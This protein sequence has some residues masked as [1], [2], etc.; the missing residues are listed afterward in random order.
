MRD[1]M[2]FSIP[3][4]VCLSVM[5]GAIPARGG[6]YTFSTIDFPGAGCTVATGINASGQIV[7]YYSLEPSC[8]GSIQSFV[9]TSGTFTTINVPGANSTYAQGINASGDVSG[10]CFGGS[11]DS[12]LLDTEGNYTLFEFP[13]ACGTEAYG[14]NNSEQIVGSYTFTC[15]GS[16][17][18]F[19]YA[20]GSFS[21]LDFP[22]AS[23]GGSTEAFGINSSGNIVGRYGTS[24]PYVENN[25][26]L[27]AS[28][29]FTT[30][31]VPGAVLTSAI[32]INDTGTITGWYED[33]ASILHGFVLAGGTFTTI[34]FPGA[35]FTQAESINASGEVAGVYED[36]AGI[37][38]FLATPTFTYAS[39]T[40]PMQAM[41]GDLKLSP[42]QTLEV[43]YDFTMP[44][45]HPSATVNFSAG[46]VSFPYTCVSGSGT[47]TLI[48]PFGA[49]TYTDNQNSSAWIPSGNQQDPS[50]FQGQIAVPNV[51]NG[52]EVQFQQG[53]AFTTGV[54]ST[55]STDKV[56]ARWHYSGSGSAG[57]WSG[58]QS[59]VPA[60]C[61][62]GSGT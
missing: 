35:A 61:S 25:G 59:V 45:N 62:G 30:I 43:G 38:G 52:G 2:M 22:G 26:F 16:N 56:N 5:L 13:G 19:L 57:S 1:M 10:L 20:G 55:D 49:E 33:S 6:A 36:A 60:S 8:G 41:E 31:D 27:L 24:G 46:Q 34:D 9:L 18:G 51:C 17:H 54:C 53:G 37:H 14:I 23:P 50:V 44:G 15:S 58:T 48:V 4:A 21:T 39:L 47:G 42:G 32:G 11:C 28:G 3:I 12:F 40:F 29:S 7:G